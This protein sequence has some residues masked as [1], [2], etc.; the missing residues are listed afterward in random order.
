M[1]FLKTFVFKGQNNASNVQ[2]DNIQRNESRQGQQPS[3]NQQQPQQQHHQ[4]Y[5][6]NSFQSRQFQRAPSGVRSNRNPIDIF[7]DV[8]SEPKSLI[9]LSAFVLSFLWLWKVYDNLNGNVIF[10]RVKMI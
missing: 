10:D 5:S 8:A 9:F 6:Q 4:N 2:R 1:N 7:F 3:Q